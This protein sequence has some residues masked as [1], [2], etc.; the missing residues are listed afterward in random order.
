MT[1]PQSQL[2]PFAHLMRE[3]DS[4][5]AW[6]IARRAWHDHGLLVVSLRSAE[7]RAG[8]VAARQARTLGEQIFGKRG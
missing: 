4:E 1:Q 3:P 5:Q 2:A 6:E 7:A 8:W